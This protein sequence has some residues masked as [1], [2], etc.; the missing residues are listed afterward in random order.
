MHTFSLCQASRSAR[1]NFLLKIRLREACNVEFITR[2]EKLTHTLSWYELAKLTRCEIEGCVMYDKLLLFSGIVFGLLSVLPAW[3]V[4][5][6]HKVPIRNDYISPKEKKLLMA[7]CSVMS[8][9]ML[10]L[11]SMLIWKYR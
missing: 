1:Q 6:F 3:L 8:I 2:R 10:I 11:S 7:L 9:M 5:K 4:V